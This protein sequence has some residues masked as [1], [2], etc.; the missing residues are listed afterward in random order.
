MCQYI[1]CVSIQYVS[2][3]SM[4][5]YIVC[6]SIQYVSV[7]SMCQYT[8]CDSIQYVSVYS[9]C[10]YNLSVDLIPWWGWALSC[11]FSMV[12]VGAV[13]SLLSSHYFADI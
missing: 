11:L 8:D 9:M 1:V 4:C 2:V 5:Q 12:G 7:Y 6:V 13:M 3:Y 10:Q